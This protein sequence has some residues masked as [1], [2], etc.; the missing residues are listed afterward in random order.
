MLKTMA[1]RKN[2]PQFM[3]LEIIAEETRIDLEFATTEL[4]Q[5]QDRHT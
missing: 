4:R 3:S 2:H 5:H 1:A